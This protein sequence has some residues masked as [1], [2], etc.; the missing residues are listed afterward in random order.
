MVETCATAR[1]GA[2]LAPRPCALHSVV[3][4]APTIASARA[5]RTSTART[6]QGASQAVADPSHGV[7]SA[8]RVKTV[9]RAFAATVFKRQRRLWRLVRQLCSSSVAKA[10]AGLSDRGQ[11]DPHGTCKDQSAT[12]CGQ[13]GAC[14]GFGACSLYAA[15]ETIC[16]SPVCSGARLNTAGTCDGQG[17]CRAP[18]VQNCWPYTCSNGAC[19]TACV[20]DGDCQTGHACV[21]GSCGPK[22]IGQSCSSPTDCVSGFCV[23]GTCCDGAC[24]GACTSC[25]LPSS[26]GHCASVPAN[27]TDPR[28][29]CVDKGASACSTGRPLRRSRR[30]PGIQVRHRLR[31]RE[32]PSKRLHRPFDLQRDRAMCRAAVAVLRAL[33]LQ[34]RSLLRLL[35]E[36]RRLASRLTLATRRGSCGQKSIGASCSIASRM[37]FGLLRA[38]SVLRNVLYGRVQVMRAAGERGGLHRC[39]DW[40]PRSLGNVRRSGRIHLRHE[41]D[42]RGGDVPEISSRNAL[43]ERD[44]SRERD[45]VHTGIELRR[46][47]NLHHT[48]VHVLR[49]L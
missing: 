2:S 47:G 49:A 28:G 24:G 27:A 4:R 6:A 35:S 26:M 5:N 22:P 40:R 36:Q 42:V 29:L 13:T 17:A 11:Q 7:P 20:S 14:D 39:P 38:R 19:A 15:A 45:R 3:T 18:G 8:Q 43:R 23:D 1:D 34:R 21:A 9:P 48:D 32:L 37:R 12:S 31:A 30:L 33:R 16:T 10:H 44:L 46:R 41:R 25:A